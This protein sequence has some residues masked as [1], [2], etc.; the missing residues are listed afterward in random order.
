[1][2]LLNNLFTALSGIYM[3]KASVSAKCNK[4]GVLLYNSLFSAIL[5][6]SLFGVEHMYQVYNENAFTGDTVT[7]SNRY[8][9]ALAGGGGDHKSASTV[10]LVWSYEGWNEWKFAFLFL[11][12]ALMGSVLNYSIFL[13]TTVNSALTTAVV[14]CLKNVL[15]T[16]IGTM[17]YINIY[18]LLKYKQPNKCYYL[19]S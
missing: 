16:Y 1:M 13:C 6:F 5:L 14:G 18:L 11:L 3:K 12:A 17:I 9:F 19:Y 4:M 7:H 15:T 10:S 8:M 2:V